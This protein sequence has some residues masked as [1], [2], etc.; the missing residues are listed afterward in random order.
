MIST[1]PF[2]FSMLANAP[3]RNGNARSSMYPLIILWKAWRKDGAAAGSFPPRSRLARCRRDK[4]TSRLVEEVV[5]RR[6]RGATWQYIE[7]SVRHVPR[8]CVGPHARHAAPIPRRGCSRWCGRSR[9]LGTATGYGMHGNV[10]TLGYF[11]AD[12]CLGNF[13]GAQQK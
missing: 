6:V 12:V 2:V 9:Q 1:H 3:A 4:H 5:L 8:C 13:S 10:H 7:K 11:S